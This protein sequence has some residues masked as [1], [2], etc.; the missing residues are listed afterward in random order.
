MKQLKEILPL[1]NKV[2]C[3]YE[4]LLSDIV[5]EKQKVQDSNNELVANYLWAE[6]TIVKIFRI[7][8]Q[9]LTYLNKR[10][11]TKLGALQSK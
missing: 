1:L 11:F 4:C 2:G 10:N 7:L 6:E 3:D 9:C 5:T 8:F